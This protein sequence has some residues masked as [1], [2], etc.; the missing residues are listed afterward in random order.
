[1]VPGMKLYGGSYSGARCVSVVGSHSGAEHVC[2]GSL[3][4]SHLYL[5]NKQWVQP[6]AYLCVRCGCLFR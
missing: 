6:E 3:V 2:T 1:M 5:H 4:L